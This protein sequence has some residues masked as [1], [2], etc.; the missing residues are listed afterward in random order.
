MA[1]ITLEKT[2]ALLEK[3]A[4]YV[5]TEIPAIKQDIAIIKQDVA[6]LKQDVKELKISY[7]NLSTDHNSLAQ[8]VTRLEEKMDYVINAL[9]AQTKKIDDM[10]IEQKAQLY[11]LDVYNQRIGDLEEKVFGYRVRDKED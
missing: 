1:E 10:L 9:D 5:M 3:L 2:Y 7:F 8:R 11:T 4:E 6:G